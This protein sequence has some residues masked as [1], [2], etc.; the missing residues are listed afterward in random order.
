VGHP[1][2]LKMVQGEAGTDRKRLVK[3]GRKSSLSGRV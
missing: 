3:N 1:L 2:S